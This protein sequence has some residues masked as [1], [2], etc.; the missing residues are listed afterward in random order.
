MDDWQKYVDIAKVL[1]PI[2][3][4]VAGVNYRLKKLESDVDLI[5]YMFRGRKGM[6][7]RSIISRVRRTYFEMRKRYHGSRLRKGSNKAV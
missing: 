4:W 5:F 7:N 2:A 1:W 3:L 6:R